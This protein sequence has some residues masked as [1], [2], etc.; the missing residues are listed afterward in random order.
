MTVYK[1][2]M[3]CNGEIVTDV[4]KMGMASALIPKELMVGVENLVY[5]V[6][7]V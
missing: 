2:F 5:L 4:T 6:D 7:F 3:I 1:G